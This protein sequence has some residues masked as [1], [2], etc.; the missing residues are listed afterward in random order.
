MARVLVVEDVLAESELLTTV[1]VP[2]KSVPLPLY[3]RYGLGIVEV[4]TPAGSL[5]GGPGGI[6]GFFTIVLGTQDARRQMGVMVNIGERANARL[7]ETF[8]RVTRA[9]GERLLS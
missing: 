6:P 1:P 9:L 8:L 2:P 5:F 4:E 7:V 3:D